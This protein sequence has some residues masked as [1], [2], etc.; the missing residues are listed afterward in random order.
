PY[1]VRPMEERDIAQSAE[2][3]RDAFPTLFPPTSFR[4]EL[5]NRI[6]S[7][8][9][10]WRRDQLIRQSVAPV[11]SSDASLDSERPLIGKLFQNARNLLARRH[12]VWE[13]GQQFIAG[14]LGTWYM[15]EEA[16]IVAVGVRSEYRGQGIGELLL[17]AG[18][19]QAMQNNALAVTLEVRIS[20]HVAQN[21]YR[22]Y[23]FSERGARKGY[24][25]DNREDALIMTTERINTPAFRQLFVELLRAH[26]ERWG[27][28]ERIVF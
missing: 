3:E 24:Y 9:V 5:K 15:A 22:K 14:F 10:V 26:E 23:G 27:E 4:R 2:I 19:E 13:P 20:N 25:T 7:Y 17:I 18:I 8:L 21:L 6:A 11:L 16:H 1:A 28:S 12:T